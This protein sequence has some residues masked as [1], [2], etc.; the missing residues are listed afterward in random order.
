MCINLVSLWISSYYLQISLNVQTSTLKL[1]KV[2]N[3]PT[4]INWLE[5]A[6]YL[7]YFV[8][9]YHLM[10]VEVSIDGEAMASDFPLVAWWPPLAPS[11][12]PGITLRPEELSGALILCPMN[13]HYVR[14][15]VFILQHE[16]NSKIIFKLRTNLI[17]L[18][19]EMCSLI[20]LLYITIV[21][22]KPFNPNKFSFQIK[23]EL[24]SILL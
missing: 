2:T 11:Q 7:H 21:V 9:L 3:K 17:T 6:D 16:R 23:L 15:S 13:N 4:I 24:H 12:D 10:V 19:E 8:R 14:F 20:F 5:H 22:C 18:R 1:L